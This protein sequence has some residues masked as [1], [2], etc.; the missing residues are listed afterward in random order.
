MTGRV[1]LVHDYLTQRGGAE[2]VVL[3]MLRA[4]PDAPLYTSLYEADRTFPEFRDAEVRLSPLAGLPLLGRHHRL[5]L[6]LLAPTFS[7]LD[8]DAEVVLCSSSGWAHGACARGRKIVYCH[9]PA[10]W[11]YQPDRYLR[12][13]RALTRIGFATLRP[14]LVRWDRR[15]ASTADRYVANSN[16]VREQ[17]AAIY[18]RD[19]E[20]VH[21]PCTIEPRGPRRPVA[22]VEPGFFLC[23]ARLLPYKNVDAVVDAF[24]QPGSERLVI[25]GAGPELGRLHAAAS[26]NVRFLGE[27]DTKSLRWL[28][29][30][31]AGLIAA[32]YEDF[33][34]TPVEA[35]AFG[36]PTAALRFG[37]FLDTVREGGTGCFF[38]VA[39]AAAIR[40][41]VRELAS[42]NWDEAAIAAHAG[43]FSE[44]AF[45]TRLRTIVAERAS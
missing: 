17:I 35:A 8:V 4:F 24:A 45:V 33:G 22:D 14:S 28:Y 25:V 2:R 15:A 27:V 9:A 12:G 26:P 16:A 36:K 13:S 30:S 41:A 3:S 20:V 43:R 5:A 39:C 21:P 40:D 37:G 34:L 23:V 42:T 18:G 7:R 11:L 29:A 31:C 1:A 19:A 38:D 10:R 44:D 32:G 6:P